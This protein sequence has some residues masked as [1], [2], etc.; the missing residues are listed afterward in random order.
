MDW[1]SEIDDEILRTLGH[2][3]GAMEPAELGVALGMSEA[4][5]CSCLAMLAAQHKVRITAVAPVSEPACVRAA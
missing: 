5:V 2:N 3:G 4:A 1:W